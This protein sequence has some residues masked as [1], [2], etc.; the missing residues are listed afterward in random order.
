MSYFFAISIILCFISAGQEKISYNGSGNYTLRERTDLR[1]YDNGKYIGLVSREVTSFIN[2]VSCEDGY[3]YEGNFY[4]NQKTNH[5]LY[6]VG[7]TIS[8]YIY[9]SFKIDDK[10]NLKMFVDNGFPTFRSF[11]AFP[12]KK[13]T[14]GDGIHSR[15]SCISKGQN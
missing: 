8:D 15:G 6:R 3:E 7:N 9:A 5:N 1:R 12:D 10:G 13:I 4:V 14:K 2:P 11:P